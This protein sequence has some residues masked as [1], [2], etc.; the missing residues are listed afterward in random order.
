MSG[1]PVDNILARLTSV[2]PSGE[3]QWMAACPCRE[4][5]NNPSLAVSRGKEGEALVYCHR[6]TCDAKKIFQSVGLDLA[7][8]GFIESSSSKNAPPVKAKKTLVLPDALAPKKAVQGT[9]RF[10]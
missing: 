2:K 8:D 4:D 7:K 3:N 10:F 1:D 6:G 9:R 5:D